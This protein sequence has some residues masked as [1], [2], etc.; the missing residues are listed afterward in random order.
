MEGVKHESAMIEMSQTFQHSESRRTGLTLLELLLVL[1]IIV[2]VSALTIPRLTGSARRQELTNA[3]QRVRSTLT[4][5][6]NLAMR[7]GE[8]AMFLFQPQSRVYASVLAAS[9]PQS[10]AVFEQTQAMLMQMA[11]VT[12][13]AAMAGTTQNC[14]CQKLP[15]DVV[16]QQIGIAGTATPAL[17]ANGGGAGA[18]NAG[19]AASQGT[20]G[21][22]GASLGSLL[23]PTDMA[24]VPS[25][26]FYP[27][28][29]A[30]EQV[31]MLKD[32]E[33]NQ[34]VISVR[35]LTGG[36]SVGELMAPDPNAL[37][38]GAL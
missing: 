30:D 10:V 14:G 28:G 21:G 17:A 1:S 32:L 23:S 20:I 4:K 3:A 8:P 25:V 29:T 33:G 16:F 35:G 11:S 26:V 37:L 34:V 27:D 38:N 5:T 13:D 12:E 6:R 2:V 9:D 22:S 31:V 15:M 18:G 7:E 24:Q 36:I 19:A